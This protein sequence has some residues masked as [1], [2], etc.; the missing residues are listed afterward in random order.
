MNIFLY[1]CIRK[2]MAGLS[3]ALVRE[4]SPGNKEHPT[5]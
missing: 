3:P 4:E 1:F 2:Q 5:S